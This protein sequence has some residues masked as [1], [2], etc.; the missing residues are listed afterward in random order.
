MSMSN[1]MQIS[2]S[3]EGKRRHLTTMTVSVQS[4]HFHFRGNSNFQIKKES[5]FSS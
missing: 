4:I 2:A 1:G 3:R 5:T